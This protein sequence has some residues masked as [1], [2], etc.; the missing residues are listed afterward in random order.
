M[1]K[2]DRANR[3]NRDR[4]YSSVG[5]YQQQSFRVKGLTRFEDSIDAPNQLVHHGPYNLHFWALHN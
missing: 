3:L 5:S 1:L 2:H 4:P